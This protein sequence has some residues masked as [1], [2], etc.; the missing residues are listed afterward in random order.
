MSDAT[1]LSQAEQ[2]SPTP[3][4]IQDVIEEQ[5]PKAFKDRVARC[6]DDGKAFAVEGLRLAYEFDQLLRVF[7]ILVPDIGYPGGYHDALRN[8]VRDK[9]GLDVVSDLLGGVAERAID[10]IGGYP[11]EEGIKRCRA[12]LGGTGG[13]DG[14]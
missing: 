13:A 3:E 14:V 12:H 5:L 9:I 1:R 10:A 7:D 6:L 11:G 8:A 2:E 4:S